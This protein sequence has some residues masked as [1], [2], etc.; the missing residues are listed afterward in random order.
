MKLEE[1]LKLIIWGA[2]AS[3]KGTQSELIEQKYGLV[4]IAAG[5]LLRSEVSAGSEKGK[6]AKEY[7]EKGM[8]VPDDVIFTVVKER[9]SQP[10]A[11]KNGWILDGYPRSLSQ[12]NALQDLG[13]RPDLFI[14]LDVPEE[15][16]IERVL[17]RRLD[18]VTGKIYHLKNSPPENEE[19]AAR[20]TQRF[21][22][23]EEKIKLRLH[24]HHQNEEGVLS[25]YKDIIFKVSGDAPKEDVFAEIDKKLSSIVKARLEMEASA[26]AAG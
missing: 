4:H 9:L 1:P 15:S 25:I 5:D 16:L 20:L 14:L 21:D 11:Q 7:M 18:P 23:T 26:E 24:N 12:A 13:I 19:I 22:D 6:K 8:L 2:P 10:D 17:G 3:G